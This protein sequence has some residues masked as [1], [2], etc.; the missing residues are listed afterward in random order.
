[1]KYY[2]IVGEASGDLHASKL[3]HG[4]I[5]SD[6][7]AEFRFWGGDKMTEAVSTKGTLVKHH[8]E[9][10]FMGFF[11]VVKNL[12]TILTQMSLCRRDIV[13]FAPD[14][15][16]LVDYAGFNLRIAKFAKSKGIRT[17]Y[18][19]A[20]K[21][22]AWK[23]SRV[24][25]I[26]KYV[27]E[28][29]VIFPFEVEYF[30]RW[31]VEAYYFGNPIMDAIDEK[32]K[33]LISREKFISDNALD[34]RP[35][36]ALL[37]G[38]RMNEIVHNLPFMVDVVREFK[39]YQAVV[40][41]VDWIDESVYRRF[42]DKFPELNIA[43]VNDMTYAALA[44]SDAAIVTSGTATLETALLGTP[45]LACYWVHPLSAVVAWMFLKLKWV[46]LVNII[47][48]KE[49]ITELL[50]KDM[51]V[52]SAVR[53]IRAILPGGEKHERLKAD[54]GLLAD[55]MGEKGASERVAYKMVELLKK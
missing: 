21:V 3:M 8:R 24:K 54:Y 29:F 40:C 18:Y 46:T 17:F 52:E 39:D 30:R 33:S 19:I 42:T 53:E 13:R 23:E 48:Q 15:V 25:K 20:P 27:D 28:L 45:E 36:I 51:K 47:M 50:Y 1:M 9:T 16:I 35:K 31:G 12:K 38:S 34:N 22:W 6:P 10:S 2:V 32:N 49:V 55:A 14:V 43:V 4:I 44:H 11:E 5:E 37:P 41:K 7:D 26:Q